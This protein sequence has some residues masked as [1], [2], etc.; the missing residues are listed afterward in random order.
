VNAPKLLPD[1]C[2]WIDFFRGRETPLTA[3]LSLALSEGTVACC[4]VVLFELLKGARQEAEKEL[5]FS[6]FSGVPF[7]ELSQKL[8]VEAGNLAARLRGQ[9]A[10][11]PMSDVLIA[12][13]AI[14]HGATVLTADKHF[15]TIPELK[16]T[17]GD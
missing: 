13:L 15:L 17:T 16:T 11:L 6:S 7:L 14:S 1:T 8:W 3:T 5:I 10:T 4:G 9:G 2:A 12:V